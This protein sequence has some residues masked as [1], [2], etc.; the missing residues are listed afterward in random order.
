MSNNLTG[1]DMVWAITQNTINSQLQWLAALPNA[2]PVT[3]A[4]GSLAD[5]EQIS[6]GLGDIGKANVFPQPPV[7]GAPIVDFNTS[8]PKLVNFRIPIKSGKAA[9]LAPDMA[10]RTFAVKT[11]DISGAIL[12]FTVDVNVGKHAADQMRAG[13]KVPQDILDQLEKF[14]AADFEI[15]SIFLDFENSDLM[16]YDP[17]LSSF[18]PTLEKGFASSA[19]MAMGRVLAKKKDSDNPFFLGHI[20]QRKTAP[21]DNE[22]LAPNGT[23]YSTTPYI[24]VGD[25]PT[26][27]ELGLSTF[28]FLLVGGGKD[29]LKNSALTGPGAGVFSTNFVPSN[30]YDGVGIIDRNFYAEK[31]LKPFFIDPL[32]ATIKKVFGDFRT[33]HGGGNDTEVHED[34]GVLVPNADGVSWRYAQNIDLHWSGGGHERWATRQLEFNVQLMNKPDPSA[35]GAT[36]MALEVRGKQ[37]RLEKEQLD[38]PIAHKNIGGGWG[39]AQFSSTLTIFFT[40]GENGGITLRVQKD[41]SPAPVKNSDDW[42]LYSL[43]DV[44]SNFLGID[45]LQQEWEGQANDLSS[46]ELLEDKNLVAASAEMLKPVATRV[47]LPAPHVFFYRDLVLNPQNDPEIR[48]TYKTDAGTATGDSVQL[49]AK[50]L[51][52]QTIA[53]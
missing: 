45:G 27:V 52:V 11:V 2:L 10:T 18:P 36:R 16:T 40:A 48:L 15:A 39:S 32:T 14:N 28:N 41:P 50:V 5:P 38:D 4:I 7:I 51:R 19:N 20:A 12:G 46:E 22:I 24:K 25:Q 21:P 17:T 33:A 31:Y 49:G 29:I 1:F 35:G 6:I 3:E 43:A 34:T 23:N 26:N 44:F 53:A 8:R 13:L 37:F 47:V 42:G 9:F 30:E